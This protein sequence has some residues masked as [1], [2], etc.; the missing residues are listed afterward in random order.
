M[1]P[2]LSP[3]HTHPGPRW[4]SPALPTPPARPPSSQ[5]PPS[6]SSR[7]RGVVS[8]RRSLQMKAAL[9]MAAHRPRAGTRSFITRFV[10]KASQSG[11]TERA[12][13]SCTAPQLCSSALTHREGAVASPGGAL[14]HGKAREAADRDLHLRWWP[15]LC[16]EAV[17]TFTSR[18]P[19]K[20]P[21]LS[22]G[23]WDRR[24]GQD[25]G[26]HSLGAR[27]GA[28]PAATSPATSCKPQ[29]SA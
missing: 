29:A 8:R 28:T 27:M 19:S 5:Q 13:R 25:P 3:G 17:P 6:S 18:P 14:G 20:S 24:L 9:I 12:Q 7:W 15:H 21:G 11:T 10:S 2:A 4:P 16:E 26:G 1:R 23:P 22:L